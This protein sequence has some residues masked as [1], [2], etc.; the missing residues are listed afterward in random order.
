M[1]ISSTTGPIIFNGAKAPLR[2]QHLKRYSDNATL[3]FCVIVKRFNTV[4]KRYRLYYYRSEHRGAV[5]ASHSY[6]SKLID[7]RYCF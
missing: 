4:E 7:L 6:R 3:R 2:G 5:I 1:K